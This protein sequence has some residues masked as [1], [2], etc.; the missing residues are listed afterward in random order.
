MKCKWKL[1]VLLV[2]VATIAALA[3][4]KP[5]S[6]FTYEYVDGGVVITGYKGEKRDLVIP[7]TIGNDPVVGI[8]RGAFS[9]RQSEGYY[10]RSVVI[11]DSV[12]TIEQWAFFMCE[13][14][15][16]VT[17]PASLKKIEGWAFSNCPSLTNIDL[18][19]GLWEIEGGAFLKSGLTEV[20]LP[21]NLHKIG[22]DAFSGNPLKELRIPFQTTLSAN[23]GWIIF[24]AA[25]RIVIVAEGSAAHRQLLDAGIDPSLYRVE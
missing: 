19:D 13:H 11:P 20:V 16:K 1:L 17:L 5:K 21:E 12:V 3:G 10:L 7:D 9:E 22:G 23:M 15:E 24:P 25:S 2:V 14:L 4:C 18:P 6:D 8:A